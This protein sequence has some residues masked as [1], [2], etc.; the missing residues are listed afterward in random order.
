MEK[1]KDSEYSSFRDPSGYIYYEGDK[2]FRKINK[3]YIDTYDFFMSSGLYDRLVEDNLIIKH[4]EIKRDS[5][6]IVLEVERIPF[7]SYP[8]EWCFDEYRDA[9]LLT[10]KINLIALEYGMILKDASVYNIQFVDGN[11][12]FIDTLSFDKYEDGQPWGAYG[13]FTRHFIA[14]LALMNFVDNRMNTLM[15][16]YIDGIPLD[17]ADLILKKRGGMFVKQH[18]TWQSKSILKHN[19]SGKN[20]KNVKVSLS[21]KSL[22]NIFVMIDSQIKNLKKKYSLTEWD[23]YYGN[24]NYS[25]NAENNKKKI[26]LDFI[27]EIKSDKKL[28][29]DMG[30]N[31]GKYSRI[32]SEYFEHVI[33]MDIDYN[34]VNRNYNL[35]CRDKE[36]ILP[37]VLDF[38]NPTPAIGFACQ[39][40]DNLEKRMKSDMVMALALIHH[41]AISNNVPFVKIAE[42]FATLGQYLIIEFVP[43]NDSQVELLLKTRVDIFDRYTQNDFEKEFSNYFEIISKKKIKDSERTLYLMVR[44]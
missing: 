26:I 31:D 10:L 32:I 13:Q 22:I 39:E 5:D 24:T 2:V 8:Y 30:A 3:C 18:I 7:I 6:S 21:K 16:D 17:L 41:M 37:L 35:S 38:N 33:A 42:W 1:R 15:R 29:L 23:N 11:P 28:A 27:K 34:A 19:N 44:K 43:K 25:E 4:N 12:I 40:R 20:D 9:A 36:N 14:P